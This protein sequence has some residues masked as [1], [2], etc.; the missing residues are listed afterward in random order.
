MLS[1]RLW[2]RAGECGCLRSIIVFAREEKI[3]KRFIV[4]ALVAV[5][6]S[7]C[8]GI[9]TKN[10]KVFVEPPDSVITVVSGA[11][12]KE[13]KYRSPATI[14]T[15]VPKD[16]SGSS[17]AVL[18]VSR[19]NYKTQIIP[20]RDIKDGQTLNIKLEPTIRY[21]FSYRLISPAVSDTL[22]FRDSTIAVSFMFG[23]RSFQLRFENLTAR[24][25]KILWERSE[26]TD[27]NGQSHRLM[28]SG[29]RFQ[30]R[31][32]PIPD[33]IVQPRS[34]VQEAVIPI[35]KVYF[36]QEKK[37]YS[38][39]PLFELNTAAGLKGKAINLFIPVEV[40]RA[41]IPYNFKIQIIDSVKETLE[42]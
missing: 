11:E 29:I 18:T 34:S 17:K 23:D 38:V 41:I 27:T 42:G 40:D 20:L 36:V 13:L 33:Q 1:Y 12:L 28:H 2:Y 14:T 22:Q 24:N 35:S 31:N 10:F 25:V 8:S 39:R 9:A 7:A 4:A 26:Y 5:L 32:N 37:I 3:M 21:R 15:D 19:E 6:A 16:A 30:D